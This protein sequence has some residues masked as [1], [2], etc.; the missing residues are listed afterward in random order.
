MSAMI[1]CPSPT[2]ATSRK[3]DCGLCVKGSDGS[4]RSRPDATAAVA[5]VVAADVDVA[6]DADAVELLWLDKAEIRD[7]HRSNEG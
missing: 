5:A 6:V 1:T 7:D 2:P 4:V 3:L